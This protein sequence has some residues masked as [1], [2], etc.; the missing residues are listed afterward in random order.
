MGDFG[1]EMTAYPHILAMTQK[2]RAYET[3][4]SH[5]PVGGDDEPS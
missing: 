4:I 5:V 2:E 1:V 3:L